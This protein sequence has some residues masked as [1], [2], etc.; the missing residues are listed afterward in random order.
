V[1]Q[2]ILDRVAQPGNRRAQSSFCFLDVQQSFFESEW[3]DVGVAAAF[4]VS[5]CLIDEINLYAF[6]AEV[7]MYRLQTGDVSNE[8]WSGQAPEYQYRVLP[9]DPTEWKLLSVLIVDGHVGHLLSD[10]QTRSLKR[11][12]TFPRR[13]LFARPCLLRPL[14]RGTARLK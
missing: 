10:L 6:G 4:G 12:R 3:R 1:F 9:L 5:K 7:P 8:R 13:S 2:I 14:S 11:A